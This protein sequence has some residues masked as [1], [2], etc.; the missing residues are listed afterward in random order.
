MLM[1]Q[2]DSLSHLMDKKTVTIKTLLEPSTAEKLEAA[3]A[4]GNMEQLRKRMEQLFTFKNIYN[5]HDDHITELAECIVD[6]ATADD[7][8]GCAREMEQ[9]AMRRISRYQDRKE[10]ATRE[11]DWMKAAKNTDK[12]A[13]LDAK[14][15]LWVFEAGFEYSRFHM[16]MMLCHI[17]R[18]IQEQEGRE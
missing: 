12:V 1:M 5:M 14:Y 4:K 10:K 17:A 11:H 8:I 15:R 6:L 7:R 13:M 3:L 9:Y 16:Y 2:E 18:G